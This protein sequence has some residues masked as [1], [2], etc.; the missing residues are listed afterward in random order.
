LGL[1]ALG[2]AGRRAYTEVMNRNALPLLALGLAFFAAPALATHPY[3]NC[4]V[5]VDVAAA[6]KKAGAPTGPVRV[7]FLFSR[8]MTDMSPQEPETISPP[9]DGPWIYKTEVYSSLYERKLTGVRVESAKYDP[10]TGKP[11]WTSDAIEAVASTDP[12]EKTKD[13]PVV[14]ETGAD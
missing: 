14:C 9:A 5:S 8:N 7:R 3:E 2:A 6:V 13:A 4:R 1:R 10:D 11:A 12:V